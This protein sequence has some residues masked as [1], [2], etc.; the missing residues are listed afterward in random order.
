M[1]IPSSFSPP[2]FLAGGEGKKF[3]DLMILERVI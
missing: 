1:A 3:V 2:S